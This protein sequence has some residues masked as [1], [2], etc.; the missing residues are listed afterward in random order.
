FYTDVVRWF[1]PPPKTPPEQRAQALAT[2]AAQAQPTAGA[3]QAASS[4]AGAPRTIEVDTN[5]YHAVLTTR[6]ARLV[7]FRLKNYRESVA[8]NSP[9]YDLVVPGE[10]LPLGL[11][12]QIGD[13]I[14][15]DQT[16]DY[17]STAPPRIE[18]RKGSD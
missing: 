4:A 10:R 1:R 14:F 9:L 2:P 15:G 3:P 5:L 6:G 11:V 16:L 17:T 7:S 8:T 18:V 12:V 13:R